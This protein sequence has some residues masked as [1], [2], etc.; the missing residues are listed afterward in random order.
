[1]AAN[2][3]RRVA[4]SSGQGYNLLNVSN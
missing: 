4:P 2:P 1:M 3:I